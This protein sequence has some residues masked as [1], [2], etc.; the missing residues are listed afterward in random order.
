MFEHC[1]YQNL[2][3]VCSLVVFLSMRLLEV[4]DL[5][6]YDYNHKNDYS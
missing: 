2:I 5:W 1:N 6:W 3:D 4:F